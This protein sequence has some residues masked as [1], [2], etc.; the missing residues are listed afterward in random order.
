MMNECRQICTMIWAQKIRQ[1]DPQPNLQNGFAV[2]GHFGNQ[3]SKR[4]FLQFCILL[5][6]IVFSH[7]HGRKLKQIK[8]RLSVAALKTW[9]KVRKCQFWFYTLLLG[10]KIDKYSISKVECKNIS[11]RRIS[12]L[13]YIVN[14]LFP[15]YVWV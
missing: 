2:L 5:L 15:K 12:L 10:V 3:G 9:S 1:R 4:K 11:T 8:I 13:D 6:R 7:F 14:I